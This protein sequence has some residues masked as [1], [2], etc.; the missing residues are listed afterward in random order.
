MLHRD[1]ICM[2][3]PFSLL[4]T[5]MLLS[6]QDEEAIRHLARTLDP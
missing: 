2:V 4:R 5:S 3:F 6:L 1:Y